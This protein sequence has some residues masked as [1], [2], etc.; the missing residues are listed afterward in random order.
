M[1]FFPAAF[2]G[3][4]ANEKLPPAVEAAWD[5]ERNVPI[6]SGRSPVRVE[7]LEAVKVWAYKALKTMRFR[8]EIYS[9]NYGSELFDLI[10][11]P[12][13]EEVKQARAL[14]MARRALLQS[15]YIRRVGGGELSFEGDTLTLRL[16]IET[17]YGNVEVRTNG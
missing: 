6:F 14:A 16:E 9:Q 7:G 15:P 11:R 13:A 3:A 1:N 17:V 8:H 12:Y 2:P 4:A 10:G 5:F